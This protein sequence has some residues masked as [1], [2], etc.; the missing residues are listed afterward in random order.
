MCLAD[1]LRNTV[2]NV[3]G[4]PFRGR[5]AGKIKGR[6]LSVTAL[7]LGRDPQPFVTTG[8]GA[9]PLPLPTKQPAR[10]SDVTTSAIASA[11]FFIGSSPARVDAQNVCQLGL[12]RSTG[13]RG[14]WYWNSRSL[15]FGRVVW[16][17]GIQAEIPSN[18]GLY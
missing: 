17:R 1:S 18:A 4:R 2:M 9:L 10:L 3:V 6:H 7:V 13:I 11:N 8:G 16:L 12:Q 14:N 5:R 15:S